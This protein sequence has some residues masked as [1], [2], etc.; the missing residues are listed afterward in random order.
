MQEQND[1][2][3]DVADFTVVRG[4]P[5]RCRGSRSTMQASQA[6]W[7][8]TLRVM[9]IH[10]VG[11]EW[12]QAALGL[13]DKRIRNRSAFTRLHTQQI[14]GLAE[15]GAWAPPEDFTCAVKSHFFSVLAVQ[16]V[17]DVFRDEWVAEVSTSFRRS[18]ESERTP[19]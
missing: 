4:E 5:E 17:A 15:Q 8:K 9:Q 13:T 11:W 16:L 6:S 18:V 14:V 2:M 19:D 7:A 12:M 3:S 1:T 10:R